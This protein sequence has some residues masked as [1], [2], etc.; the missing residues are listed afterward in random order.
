[1]EYLTLGKTG[2]MISR[3]A[4]ELIELQQKEEI[5]SYSVLLQSAYENGINCFAVN[6]THEFTLS[7]L[8]ETFS[9]LRP[10]VRYCIISNAKS[11]LEL[12]H[13]IEHAL[14]VLECD[15]IDILSIEVSDEV[16]NLSNLDDLY[17]AAKK[18]KEEGKVQHIDLRTASF[19]CAR[20]AVISGVYESVSYTFSVSATKQDEELIMLCDTMEVGFIATHPAGIDN[21]INIP[22]SFGYF[23]Q[24]EN[25][26]ALWTLTTKELLDKV[27]YFAAH[28]P[29]NDAKFNDELLA[30]KT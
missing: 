26:I 22:L 15:F 16:S 12:H 21:L 19:C 18:M 7:A 9:K 24:F 10:D 28:L 1:M 23:N 5:D 20:E 14:E 8:G 13:D 17:A 30:F 3:T 29:I 2:L 6:A 25:L 4:L 11:S 27:L